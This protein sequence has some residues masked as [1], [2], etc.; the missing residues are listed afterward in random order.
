MS[1]KARRGVA[2]LAAL[3]LLALSAALATA[4][5][6]AALAMRRAASTSAARARVDAGV[7]RSFAEVL[8]HWS[9]ALDTMPVGSVR[10]VPLDSEPAADGPPLVRSARVQR[11]AAALY[12]VTVDVLAFT[13][14]HPLARRRARLWLE[15]PGSPGGVSDGEPVPPRVVTSWGVADLY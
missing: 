13:M 9:V 7:R 4:T 11:M 3:V 8:A 10:E 12:A 6:S 5:F 15:R 14:E 2:L 1:R